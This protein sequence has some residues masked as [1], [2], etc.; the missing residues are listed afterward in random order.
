MIVTDDEGNAAVDEDGNVQI[1]QHRA[2]EAVLGGVASTAGWAMHHPGAVKTM[3]KVTGKGL[4]MAAKGVGRIA[5]GVAKGVIKRL[6]G[7]GKLHWL[8]EVG[9]EKE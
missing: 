1:K 3:A 2:S 8:L 9:Q 7:G 5:G 6:P 4:G